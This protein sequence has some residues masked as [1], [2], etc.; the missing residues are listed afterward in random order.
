MIFARAMLDAFS[1]ATVKTT[2]PVIPCNQYPAKCSIKP[3]LAVTLTFV[4]LTLALTW[5]AWTNSAGY[6]SFDPPPTTPLVYSQHS[7]FFWSAI[8]R[9]F[10][11]GSM[12]MA[13]PCPCKIM[14]FPCML[15]RGPV[16]LWLTGWHSPEQCEAFHRAR[17]PTLFYWAIYQSVKREGKL[18]YI[19]WSFAQG[20][21]WP[22]CKRLL[23]C[24]S[25]LSCHC[26]EI[27]TI[28]SFRLCNF[29]GFSHLG[30]TPHS[31][32]CTSGVHIK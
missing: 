4:C 26:S 13:L 8:R 11:C 21:P 10:S 12:A 18:G 3:L 20:T 7:L 28:Y 31:Q 25:V 32:L 27:Y 19:G 22:L 1:S 23:L 6:G 24:H 15:L 16:G 29:P 5:D 30:H 9:I 17:R 14:W 2:T